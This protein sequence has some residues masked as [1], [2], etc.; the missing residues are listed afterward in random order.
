MAETIEQTYLLLKDQGINKAQADAAIMLEYGQT[1]EEYAKQVVDEQIDA[2]LSLSVE[3]VYYVSDG[4]CYSALN[5][6]SD[7]EREDIVLNEDELILVDKDG[8]SI[9]L[10]RV[11]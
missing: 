7:M 10:E 6:G 1:M 8:D 2:I 3:G 5:W 9:T 11:K 4:Y